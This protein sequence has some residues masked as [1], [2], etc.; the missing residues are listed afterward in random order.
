[1]KLIPSCQA[2]VPS[3]VYEQKSI[4]RRKIVISLSKILKKWLQIAFEER[5]GENINNE[6]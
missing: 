6:L 5:H 4:F 3:L 2:F 1:M